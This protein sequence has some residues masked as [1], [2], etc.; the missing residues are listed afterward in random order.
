MPFNSSLFVFLFAP[1]VI[2]FGACLPVRLA[3][4]FLLFASV[5]FYGWGEPKFVFVVFVSALLDYVLARAIHR[6][7]PR[8]TSRWYLTVG[9]ALNL[10]LLV[11]CKYFGWFLQNLGALLG[12][13]KIPF[14]GILLPLGISFVVFEKIS[15]LVDVYRGRTP[16]ARTFLDYLFFVFFFPKMLAGP[17][18]KYHEIREQIENRK[19]VLEDVELGVLRFLVGLA[20]KVLVADTM[21]EIVDKVFSANAM[22]IGN[23]NVWFGALCFAIQIYFDFSGYSD[24][25]I[26]L[27][28]TFGFRLRENFNQPYLAVGFVDFWQ[29]WHIS[30]STWIRDYLY[31][32]LGG[33]RTTPARM[34]VNL[35]ICFLASGLWHG[36]NWTF[37]VW[38][39]YHG[40]FVS[41]DHLWLRR[42]WPRI[43]VW[44]GVAVTFLLV[45]VGWVIFRATSLSQA[46]TMLRLLFQPSASPGINLQLD[47][48]AIFFVLVGLVVSFTPLPLIRRKLRS[49]L[50]GD[51][52]LL[53][54][55]LVAA[56]SVWSFGRLF[57]STFHPFIYFRF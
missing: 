38:G 2:L 48:H 56:L 6:A 46:V 27:A 16:P 51:A 55:M 39:A 4:T 17:I 1:V 22:E 28:R 10:G 21:A 50:E 44:A 5:F 40:I 15:Y 29:R 26:G 41:A 7:E 53:P 49:V 52:M 9:I 45:T 37:I 11:Y 36:A 12:D 14:A 20:K 42:V 23:A 35:W 33:S 24:M 54:E 57:A 18:I 47:D 30:L 32:P 25:A 34:Y 19:V 43:P 13:L 3:T 31:I 8:R